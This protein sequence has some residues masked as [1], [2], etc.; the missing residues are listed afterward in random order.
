MWTITRSVRAEAACGKVKKAALKKKKKLGKVHSLPGA[1]WNLW[2]D[3][4][5]EKLGPVIYAIISLTAA[6]CVRVT[7]A[8]QLTV[9]DFDFVAARVWFDPFKNHDGLHK[10]MVP[11]VMRVMEEWRKNG[12]RASKSLRQCGGTSSG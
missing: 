7:Q 10:A 9:G 4:V 5:L 6:F 1:L 8:A 11:S 2:L 3:F 12:L